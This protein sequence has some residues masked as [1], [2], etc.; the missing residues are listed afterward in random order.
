MESGKC[1]DNQHEITLENVSVP[2][3]K[4]G[5]SIDKSNDT[6][7][8]VHFRKEDHDYEKDAH[9]PIFEPTFLYHSMRSVP[10]AGLPGF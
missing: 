5:E 9:L 7:L 2:I 4:R 6:G 3:F 10:D 8:S 1:E